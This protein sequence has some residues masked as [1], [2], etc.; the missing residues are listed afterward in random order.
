VGGLA[1]GATGVAFS[2]ATTCALG[3]VAKHYYA[4]GGTVSTPMLKDAYASTLVQAR[5]PQTQRAPLIEQQART[6]DVNR[7]AQMVRAR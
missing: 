1:R 3:Q 6:L 2:F 5:G 4:G 7:L